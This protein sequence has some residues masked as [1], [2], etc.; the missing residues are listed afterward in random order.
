MR[1]AC[2]TP[3]RETP[4]TSEPAPAP[5]TARPRRSLWRLF[6]A[7]FWPHKAWFIGGTALA[8]LTALWGIGYVAVLDFV[9]NSLQRQM[10]GEG[11][12]APSG[13]IYFAV[14]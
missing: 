14:A 7:H 2:S 3:R 10:T 1:T 4:I 13:L 11:G 12:G 5:E 9:G 8:L 6:K